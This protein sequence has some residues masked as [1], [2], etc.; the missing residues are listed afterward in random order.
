MLKA[1]F[2]VWEICNLRKYQS[3]LKGEEKRASKKPYLNKTWPNLNF[4]HVFYL[5]HG[6]NGAGLSQKV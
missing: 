1:E 2:C 6:T 4:L 3:G 5:I